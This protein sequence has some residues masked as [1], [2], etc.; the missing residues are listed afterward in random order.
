M[1]KI[2]L[3]LIVSIILCSYPLTAGASLSYTYNSSNHPDSHLTNDEASV[4]QE[5][6]IAYGYGLETV[7]L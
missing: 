2:A 1:K 7:H 4:L 6:L 3:L 5:K